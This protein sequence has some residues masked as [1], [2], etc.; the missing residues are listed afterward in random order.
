M[1]RWVLRV[2]AYA[3]LMTDE[4][5]PFRLDL[6]GHEPA[7]TITLTKPDTASPGPPDAAPPAPDGRRRGWTGG[8]VVSL[9]IGSVLGLASLGLLAGGGAAT[10]LHNT[11]RDAAGYLSSDTHRF[12]TSSYAITSDR[13]DLG[14]GWSPSDV[15]GTVRI[16][17]TAT[18]PTSG[19]FVG[20]APRA[21]ADRYLAGVSHAVVT[22]WTNGDTRYRQE[23]GG[24]PST[25][26]V[27][28]HIW[29]ASASGAGT[30]TLTWKPTAGDWVI[31]VMNPAGRAGVSVT[32]DAG[33]TVPDLGWFA[34]GLFVAGFLL[35][36]ASVALVAVPVVRASR[37]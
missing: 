15:L 6:G 21:A 11:Q 16:R 35:L 27:A 19:V 30:Q 25:P 24:A 37:S 22:D 33:A 17:A 36:V 13:I 29:T 34:A 4:Y 23:A 18:D 12:A 14:T 26:P 7:G 5:P 8:R 2:A 9:V 3:G 20:V 28:A 32:A 10:W 1:N 31:V